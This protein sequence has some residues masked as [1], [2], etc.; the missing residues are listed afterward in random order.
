MK[1]P[2]TGSTK[3]Q[4]IYAADRLGGS[5]KSKQDSAL[6]AG[7]SLTVAKNAQNK[8]ESTD[9]YKNAMYELAT[10]SNNLLLGVLAEYE[11][12]GLKDFSNKD[13]TAATNAITKAWERIENKRALDANKDPENNSLR[14]II[15]QRVEN[16]TVNMGSKE[17]VAKAPIDVEVED[18]V[19]LD[20]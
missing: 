7:F 4:Y 16:Q 19:D 15:L 20:F 8:I 9:G 5:G 13:L 11:R 1:R 17:I 10:K 12:R 6:L 14:K 18:K 2:K 3:S